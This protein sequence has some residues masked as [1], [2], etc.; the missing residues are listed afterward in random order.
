MTSE[1]VCEPI[2]S[3]TPCSASS[4]YPAPATRPLPDWPRTVATDY[5]N[6]DRLVVE[7]DADGGCPFDARIFEHRFSRLQEEPQECRRDPAAY[8]FLTR[9]SKRNLEYGI[10]IVL[11]WTDGELKKGADVECYARIRL[12]ENTVVSSRRIVT[13]ARDVVT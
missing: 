6:G 9:L 12:R 4:Q 2:V 13:V 11:G 8:V 5:E 7:C 3:A 1:G 10:D